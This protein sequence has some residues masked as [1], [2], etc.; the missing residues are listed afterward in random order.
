MDDDVKVVYFKDYKLYVRKFN[1]HTMADHP[2]IILIAKR[3]SGK[4]W[5]CRDILRH[6]YKKLPVGI[7]ISKTEAMNEPFYAQFFPDTFIYHE[8]NSNILKKLFKRQ[9][10]IVEK[11]KQKKLAGK[12][13]NPTAFLLMDDCLSESKKWANDPFIAELMFNGRHHKIMFLLTMQT[14]LGIPPHLRSNFDY[15]I[16]LA[17]DTENNMKKLYDNYAGIFKNV[18]EFKSIFK[19]LTVDHQAMIIANVSA[20]KPLKEK[21]F[22]Y[23]ASNEDFGKIGCDQL[24]NYH[25]SNFD[26]EFIKN[27]PLFMDD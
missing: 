8:F 1:L 24:K 6:Y 9:F 13:I 23:R 10:Q 14:P 5:V 20:D 11:Y 19:Q 3:R 26:P 21:I 16:L 17:D 15:F 18:K 22:W 27:N 25:N 12:K 4:S 7:I 2:A